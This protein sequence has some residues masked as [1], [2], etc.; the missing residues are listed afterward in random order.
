MSRRAIPALH[1]DRG[2]AAVELIAAVPFVLLV[3]ALA[4]QLALAG[5]TLWMTAHAARVAARADAVGRPVRPA[6]RSALPSVMRRGLEVD[7]PGTGGVRVRARVPL[8]LGW[9]GPVA[10]SSTASLGRSR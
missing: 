10:V 6:A 5:W 9:P 1:R 3:G 4:W 7:R 8:L 2:Q